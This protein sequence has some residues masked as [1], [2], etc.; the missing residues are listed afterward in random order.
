MKTF[1]FGIVCFTA[2]LVL[3]SSVA[4]AEQSDV[5]QGTGYGQV[6]LINSTSVTLDFYVNGEYAGRVFAGGFWPAQARAGDVEL[7]ARTADGSHRE[8]YHNDY[9]HEGGILDWT[10]SE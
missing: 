3:S 2:V 4:F 7:L 5:D 1:L 9:V 8:V 10:I 6:C